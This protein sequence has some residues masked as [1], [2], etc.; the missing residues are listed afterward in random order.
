MPGE[1]ILVVDDNTANLKLV[2]VVLS[3]EGYE[4]RA[5]SGGAEAMQLLGSEVKALQQT[6]LRMAAGDPN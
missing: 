1:A 2:S 3:A 4:V 5:A 6:G